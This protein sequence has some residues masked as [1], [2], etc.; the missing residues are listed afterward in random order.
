VR[1]ASPCLA[2]AAIL[3]RNLLICGVGGVIAPCAGIKIIDLL[4]TAVG[5]AQARLVR[6]GRSW[7]RAGALRRIVAGNTVSAI[8]TGDRNHWR[9]LG[10]PATCR[11]D[12]SLAVGRF[13]RALQAGAPVEPC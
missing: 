9:G 13:W 8:R 3:R 1:V 12:T 10:S 6:V 4:I 7:A 5:L 11:T 2:E